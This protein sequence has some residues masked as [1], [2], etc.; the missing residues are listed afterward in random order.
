M[1][2]M[3]HVNSGK[4]P[5]EA[6]VPTPR[7]LLEAEATFGALP[8]YKVLDAGA[9]R[10]VDWAGYLEEIRRAARAL[11]ALGVKPGDTVCILGF[12]RPEWT[13]SAHAAM[14]I[15]AAP[16]G[17]YFTSSAEEIAYILNHSQAPVLVAENAEHFARVSRMRGELSHLSRVVMMRGAPADDPLQISW[18]DFEKLGE[19]KLQGEVDARLAA[20]G[21]ADTGMRIYTSGTTGPPKAVVLSHGA[22]SWTAW[23]LKQMFGSDEKDRIV[24]YLPLAHIAEASN[25]IINHAGAGYCIAFAQSLE[26]LRDHLVD[27]RPTILFGVP[28]VW[29]KVHDALQGRLASATGTRAKLAKWA[30]AT[31][32]EVSALQL[33]G[34]PLGGLLAFKHRIADRLV[35]SKIRSAIGLDQCRLPVSGAAPISR[36]VLEFFAALGIVVHEV[37]G[38]SEDCGPTTFNTPGAIKLGTVGRPIPGM[39]L[40]I[41]ADDE[42]L[43]R[44]PSLF[45]GYAGDEKATAATI[46]D[47]WMHTGDLGRI[48]N[49]GFV[50]IIGRKKDILITSGGKNITPSNIEIALA[51]IPLVE[52]AVVCGEGR[53]FLTALL[54]LDPAALEDFARRN[55]MSA[56]EARGSDRLREAIQKGVDAVN[57]RHARVEHIRKFALLPAGLSLEGGELTPTMK[58][59]RA[60]VLKKH[61]GLVEEMYAA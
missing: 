21:P 11:V 25:S 58:V 34:R 8:A 38:Q 9:W 52:H 44:S 14:M 15:G 48:D 6:F 61:A 31:G 59:R 32:R 55:A 12:N 24:S 1:G 28:R 60:L 18:E 7:R 41:A 29:Q 57:E 37:Y 54:T 50:T 27:V 23:T 45:D 47:G 10:S 42:I 2:I 39:E 43:V 35:L 33:D 22:L 49:E 17:I 20:I 51:E 13:T 26:T 19:D 40:R 3:D 16:A 30:I 36:E 46:V 56:E 5:E 4:Y 53:H